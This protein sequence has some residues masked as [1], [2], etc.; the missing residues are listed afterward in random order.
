MKI[1]SILMASGPFWT[2]W[3]GGIKQVALAVMALCALFIILVVMFQPGN[4]SGISAL[5]GTTETFLGKN[6]SKTFEHKM[7][8]YTV[9]S[10]IVF[11]VLAIAFA[12][13]ALFAA[14]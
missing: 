7:K 2:A 13:V 5:G 1:L 6:K 4:S 8:I 12:I 10:G 14:L 3:H 9:I 11:S